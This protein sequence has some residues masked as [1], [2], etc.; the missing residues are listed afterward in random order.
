M[1]HF[2]DAQIFPLWQVAPSTPSYQKYTTSYSI[3]SEMETWGIP[4]GLA[5]RVRSKRLSEVGKNVPQTISTSLSLKTLKTP[6][7]DILLVFRVEY[8]NLDISGIGS[9]TRHL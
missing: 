6:C 2:L 3:H 4:R 7:H 5:T 8:H 1:Q 9:K